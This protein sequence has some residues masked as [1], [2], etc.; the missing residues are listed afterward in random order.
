MNYLF[1]DIECANCFDGVGK[2]CEFGYVLTDE[3]FSVIEENSFK[4]NPRAVFD[5][6]GF[7][8]RG[9]HLEHPFAF[10]KTQPDFPYFY[11]KIRDL[12][13]GEGLLV[14]GHGTENDV[15][16]LLNECVR[17]DMIPMN[18]KFYDTCE[19]AKVIYGRTTNLNLKALYEE[20]CAHD[21][22]QQ[23]HRS[24]EDAYMT[25]DVAKFYTKDLRK[26]FSKI[27]AAYP[28]AAGE[29][30]CGRMMKGFATALGY[31]RTNQLNKK[32][33]QLV[34]TFIHEEMVYKRTKTFVLPAEYEHD[35]FSELMVILN[36][37]KEKQLSF[38]FNLWRNC[39]YVQQEGSNRKLNQYRQYMKEKNLR[40]DVKCISMSAFLQELEL[41][42]ADLQITPE[43]LEI[44]IGNMHCNREWYTAYLERKKVD[45][46]AGKC[47]KSRL[48]NFLKKF[49]KRY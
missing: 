44:M 7:A 6:K 35:H 32:N 5:K 16:F 22:I 17:Y 46:P 38:S 1:F 49:E 34:S 39:I 25:R 42:A 21:E 4:M 15:R 20:F 12:L 3:K 9:I 31:A 23:N 27:A 8:M 37:M 43:R 14:I 29:C 28:D 11:P 48:K 40:G 33:H 26:P 24:L 45:K 18:F 19:L 2:I 30:F 13:E 10:Y 41:T 36:R 47:L